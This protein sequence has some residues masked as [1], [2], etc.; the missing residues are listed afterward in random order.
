M[1]SG[2]TTSIP[3]VFITIAEKELLAVI[4]PSNAA[5]LISLSVVGIVA[6]NALLVRRT[7]SELGI[8]KF[9]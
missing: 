7:V 1:I 2:A 6:Q 8:N 9:V 4:L 3:A 5:S